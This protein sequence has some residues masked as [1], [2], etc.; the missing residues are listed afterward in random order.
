MAIHAPDFTAPTTVRRMTALILMAL[1]TLA[2]AHTGA[3]G[4]NSFSGG[5]LHPISGLDH[6]VAMVAVGIWGAQLGMPALWVLPV[7]F[8]MVM[9]FG[10]VLGLLGVPLP[11][12]EYGIAFSGIVLGVMVATATKV[13]LWFA[14]IIVAVF[15]IFHGHAHGAELP[16]SADPLAYSAGFVLA[17][18]LL[19]VCGIAIGLLGRWRAGA[20]FMQACGAAIAVVG[21]YFLRAAIV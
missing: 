16:S 13:P 18:G 19:H 1:P 10:G 21:L 7:T 20:L 12:V 3:G 2:L 4:L 8:P 17:T 15:A 11:A 14:G 9:A 5:F 6:V